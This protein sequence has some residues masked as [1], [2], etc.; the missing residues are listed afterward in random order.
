MKKLW[1]FG[2]SYSAEYTPQSGINYELYR[3][4]KGGVLPEIWPTILGRKLEYEVKNLAIGGSANSNIFL[5]FLKVC[6]QIESGDIVIFGWSHNVRF[7]AAD[8]TANCLVNILPCDH[9]F[10][11]T[12]LSEKT[13]KEMFYNRTHPK[14][15]E[16]VYMWVK[17]INLYCGIK[18]I[19]IFH[20]TS[21]IDMK[22]FQC[23]NDGK[24]IIPV[25]S[26]EKYWTLMGYIMRENLRENGLL[27]VIKDETNNE[28]IDHHFGE[29][30]HKH[31]A[32]IF[33]NFIIKNI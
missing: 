25:V 17:F 21:D 22:H 13:I 26:E 30:G 23:V 32:K 6:E 19:N 20:W 12:N 15:L 3:I 29:Y 7:I 5:G 8:F 28:I 10:D 31:Q 11:N 14:W 4:W 9:S 24:N 16:E 2:D 27:S 18:K 33:Y 1:I